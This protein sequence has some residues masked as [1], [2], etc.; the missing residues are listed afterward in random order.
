MKT[1]DEIK[2]GLTC[3]A[4]FD[5]CQTECPYADQPHIT[6][7]CTSQLAKEALAYISMLEEQISLMRLQMHG[8]CG[9]CKHWGEYV[10]DECMTKTLRP[11][12]EY[13]G[14]PD[15]KKEENT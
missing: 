13:E 3:C 14:L 4:T 15:L 9:T 2:Q 7:L 5:R 8:D 10:C 11:H 12:W 6:D 1:P